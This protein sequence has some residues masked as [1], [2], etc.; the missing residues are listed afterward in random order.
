MKPDITIVNEFSKFLDEKEFPCI[1][2]KAALSKNKIQYLV[3]DHMA[4]PADDKKILSFIY[5]FVDRY[6]TAKNSFDSAAIIFREPCVLNETT[7]DQLLWQRLKALASLDSRNYSHDPRVDSNPASPHFSFSLKSEAFF[8][9]GLHPGS[10]RKARRFSYPSLVFNP[11]AQFEELRRLNRYTK[12][13]KTVRKRDLLYSGSIN[14]MLADFGDASEVYQ[15]SGIEYTA[16]WVCP[17][18]D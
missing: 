6:R 1:A 16:D 8:I 12:M 7:F 2:A 13:K 17:L 4:C 11:H 14:P 10:S 5:S 9:L 18:L 3:A 15:Y